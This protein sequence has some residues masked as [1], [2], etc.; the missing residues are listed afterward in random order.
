MTVHIC[1]LPQLTTSTIPNHERHKQTNPNE[2]Y[3]VIS[4]D[5][6]LQQNVASLAPVH[7]VHQKRKDVVFREPTLMKVESSAKLY[8]SKKK[9]IEN[10]ECCFDEEITKLS[11]ASIEGDVTLAQG[12]VIGKITQ[13]RE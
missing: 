6:K 1:D 8:M 2:C 7:I 11:M 9:S 3:L 5:H 13:L 12:F 10:E 4:A